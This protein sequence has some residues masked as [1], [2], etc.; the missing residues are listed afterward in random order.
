MENNA[1]CPDHVAACRP[2]SRSRTI[3]LAYFLLEGS[4][5]ALIAKKETNWDVI[6]RESERSY[7]SS[8]TE[9]THLQRQCTGHK[10]DT[11][12]KN[13][14][15]VPEVVALPDVSTD[16]ADKPSASE[17]ESSTSDSSCKMVIMEH[18]TQDKTDISTQDKTEQE[19]PELFTP[20]TPT[21]DKTNVTEILQE[22]FTSPTSSPEKESTPDNND[23]T[24]AT[25][26]N[27]E[28]MD[29]T[30]NN[31]RKSVKESK[32]QMGHL[33]EIWTAGTEIA[34]EKERTKISTTS[35]CY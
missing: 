1:L 22:L 17:T 34:Q 21:Q 9:Q 2:S 7:A 20:P 19:T 31:K 33:P 11:K 27:N 29:V 28:D 6:A 8:V 25:V 4:H 14:K 24:E 35:Q 16:A 26:E 3:R 13:N 30:Q 5:A 12:D 10:M 15:P 32:S 23:K 18:E